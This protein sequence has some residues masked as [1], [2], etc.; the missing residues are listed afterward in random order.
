MVLDGEATT[1][2]HANAPKLE[3]VQ[4]DPD[5]DVI[6]IAKILMSKLLPV[7]SHYLLPVC[8]FIIFRCIPAA[9]TTSI[10]STLQQFSRAFTHSDH[11]KENYHNAYVDCDGIIP[12]GQNFAG[13][14]RLGQDFTRS[15]HFYKYFMRHKSFHTSYS[16]IL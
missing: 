7:Q 15:F 11:A 6:G 2:P 14:P 1:K 5:L 8:E 9:C 4:V 13:K 10:E 3:Q 12:E 16:E